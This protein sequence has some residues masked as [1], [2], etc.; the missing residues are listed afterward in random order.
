MVQRRGRRPRPRP[1]DVDGRHHPRLQRHASTPFG[2]E[3]RLGQ[4]VSHAPARNSAAARSGIGR[5]RNHDLR[6]TYAS[7][8]HAAGASLVE[9]ADLLGHRT[10]EMV[11]RY[12]HS[13][14]Q[15]LKDVADRVQLGVARE[16]PGVLRVSAKGKGQKVGPKRP[17]A[18]RTAEESTEKNETI[19]S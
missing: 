11:R 6:H 18:T 2:R 9:V 7:L 13:Y 19:S 14:P 3:F 5:V 16:G 15:R 1:V 8:A 12:G 4:Q 17:E 10:L